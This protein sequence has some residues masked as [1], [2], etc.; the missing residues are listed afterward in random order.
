MTH[1]IG[2]AVLVT[3]GRDS[4]RLMRVIGF[5]QN[6]LLLADGKHRK[7]EQPKRKNPKHVTGTVARADSEVAQK[8][9][10]GE[11]I[12]NSEL[13]RDLAILG[14]DKADKDQGGN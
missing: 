5:E 13:R 7:V 1:S 6:D 4:G 9:R 2:D 11:L 8:L 10:R 12:R 14:Q 3:T